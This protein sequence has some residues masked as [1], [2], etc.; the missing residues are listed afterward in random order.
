MKS[1]PLLVQSDTQ[2]SMCIS[3]ES[4]TRTY[5]LRCLGE[6]CA[7]YH[8]QDGFCERFNST[9]NPEAKDKR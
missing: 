2:P 3:G 4:H 9:V 1:C 7:A 6:N 8:A 5:F